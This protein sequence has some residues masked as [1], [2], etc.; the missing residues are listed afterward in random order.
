M[1]PEPRERE[2]SSDRVAGVAPRLCVGFPHRIGTDPDAIRAFAQAVEAA[3]YDDLLV[4]DH[5]AGAHADRLQGPMGGFARAPYTHENPF[6][7]IFTLLGYL[8]A[9]TARIGLV[10]NVLVLPQRETV[11]VAK[12]AAEV[13]ILSRGRLRLGV[14]VGWNSVEFEALGCDFHDRGARI[15]EQVAVMRRLWAE[16]LVTFAGRWHRLDRVGINPLPGRPIPI[17]M[18]S[19]ARDVSLRRAARFFDGWVPL[20]QSSEELRSALATL[21]A[22]LAEAGRDP[23]S[24]GLGL[25]LRIED[26]P[27]SADGWRR[28]IDDLRALGATRVSVQVGG[29]GESV[30]RQL[31]R[32]ID[33]KRT[34]D[35]G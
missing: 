12:Q 15:E 7:E 21:R 13:D 17:W 31:E 26:E 19:G 1:G 9:V 33:W 11:L 10:T 24:F 29:R 35:R 28:R 34:F 8:A 4:I 16:P 18:G 14:G 25:S 20:R 3:G 5:V 23:R 6:H 32:L 27:G 30:D 2:A 22:Y